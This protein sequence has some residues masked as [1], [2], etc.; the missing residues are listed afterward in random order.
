M[1]EISGGIGAGPILFCILI[2]SVLYCCLSAPAYAG[3]TSIGPY[4]GNVTSL[5]IDPVTPTT[6]Y[7]GTGSGVFKSTN[8]GA[9]W[10]AASSGMISTSVSKLAIDPMTPTTLYAGANGNFVYKSTNGGV[11]WTM[12]VLDGACH[13]PCNRPGD[14]D[15]PLCRNW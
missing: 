15:H 7:A 3:W 12:S 8:G 14:A 4:G 13:C 9:S 6:L 1:K 2:A 5:A 11:S 10:V